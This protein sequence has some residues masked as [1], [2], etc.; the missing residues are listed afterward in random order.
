MIF[1]RL[2]LI[3]EYLT[4]FRGVFV[5]YSGDQIVVGTADSDASDESSDSWA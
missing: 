1:F 2:S 5:L 3:V 4:Y